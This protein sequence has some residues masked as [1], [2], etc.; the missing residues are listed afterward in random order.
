M[1]VQF[2]GVGFFTSSKLSGLQH[3]LA[4]EVNQVNSG[5]GNSPQCCPG[6][7]GVFSQTRIEKWC[8]CQ[9]KIKV[10]SA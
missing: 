9:S 1:T 5:A 4:D 10:G 7:R 8:S 2:L 6:G 3:N